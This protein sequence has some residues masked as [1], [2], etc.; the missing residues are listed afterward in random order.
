M[1]RVHAVA[2]FRN[3][4]HQGRV[5]VGRAR[6]D[7]HAWSRKQ[8][9]DD[10]DTAPQRRDVQRRAPSGISPG[11]HRDAFGCAQEAHSLADIVFETSQFQWR[12]LVRG[13]SRC[14]GIDGKTLFT[15]ATQKEKTA[16]LGKLS[17]SFSRNSGCG[18]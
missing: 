10:F 17:G 14:H 5:A 4:V 8:Q 2:G 3:C 9:L 16:R 15:A 18:E 12:P 1:E 11:S 13:G 6:V 7:V